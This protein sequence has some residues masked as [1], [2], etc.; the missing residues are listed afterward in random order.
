M[1]P[2]Q[3]RMAEIARRGKPRLRDQVW[4]APLAPSVWSPLVAGGIAVA[5][6]HGADAEMTAAY[7]GLAYAFASIIARFA[8][9]RPLGGS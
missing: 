3:R 5:V 8:V 6:A 7:G 9:T 2:A 4:A 1:T